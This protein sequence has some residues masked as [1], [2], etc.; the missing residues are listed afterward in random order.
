MIYIKSIVVV[1]TNNNKILTIS[2]CIN[3]DLFNILP[4]TNI[5]IYINTTLKKKK[6]K[7]KHNKNLKTTITQGLLIYKTHPQKK[8]KN[9][10][11]ILSITQ[12][13]KKKRLNLITKMTE[14]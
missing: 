7:H 3:R 1:S 11:Q 6:K 14:S 4:L 9:T 10:K 2:S 8:K 13:K 12:K 5:Y